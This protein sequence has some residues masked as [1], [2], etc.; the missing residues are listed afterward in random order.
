MKRGRKP[1]PKPI[2]TPTP[3]KLIDHIKSLRHLSRPSIPPSLPI[4]TKHRNQLT[5][6]QQAQISRI[7]K[8]SHSS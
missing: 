4:H 8:S 2:H 3:I 1:N 5:K 6:R 7:Q